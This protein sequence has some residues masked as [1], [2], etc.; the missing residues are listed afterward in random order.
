MDGEQVDMTPKPIPNDNFVEQFM[1]FNLNVMH[2]MTNFTTMM[3]R[4]T[5]RSRTRSSVRAGIG[6]NKQSI[7]DLMNGVS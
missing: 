5:I 3:S 2:Q 1:K 7:D 4:S 6:G